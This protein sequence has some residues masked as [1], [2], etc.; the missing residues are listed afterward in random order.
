M[1]KSLVPYN[2]KRGTHTFIEA[3]KRKFYII[4]HNPNTVHD[5]YACLMQGA[6]AIEPD[7]HYDASKAFYVNQNCFLEGDDL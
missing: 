6:N 7:V 1:I 3:M 5:A 4:G 2:Y